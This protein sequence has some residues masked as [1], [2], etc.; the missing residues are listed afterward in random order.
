[1]PVKA[2]DACGGFVSAAREVN[3]AHAAAKR[4]EITIP[5]ATLS[6]EET[7]IFFGSSGLNLVAERS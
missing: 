3:Q 1:M 7:F 2:T 6:S 5:N 4:S